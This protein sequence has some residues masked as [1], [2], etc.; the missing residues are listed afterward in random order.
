MTNSAFGGALEDVLQGAL[1]GAFEGA[2]EGKTKKKGFV[3][4]SDYQFKAF[5]RILLTIFDNIEEFKELRKA[6]NA[7]L[8][9]ANEQTQIFI[10]MIIRILDT[11][12]DSKAARDI[13]L[14]ILN[15]EN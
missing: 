4:M 6:L 9:P 8:T 5:L 10:A 13:I 3:R 15:S 7:L 14:Q 12:N 1:L 11:T 2:L